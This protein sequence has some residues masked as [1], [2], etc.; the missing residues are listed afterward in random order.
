[1]TKRQLLNDP[2]AAKLRSSSRK[3]AA[4]S[5]SLGFRALGGLGVL[6][7]WVL[8]FSVALPLS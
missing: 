3:L 5:S 1:M 6:G 2:C 8:R 4:M 7:V